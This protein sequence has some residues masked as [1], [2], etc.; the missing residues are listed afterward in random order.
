MRNLLVTTILLF[1]AVAGWRALQSEEGASRDAVAVVDHSAAAT[2]TPDGGVV[3]DA[4]AIE[5]ARGARPARSAPARRTVELDAV[6]LAVAFHPLAQRAERGDEQAMRMLSQRLGACRYAERNA[7]SHQARLAENLRVARVDGHDEETLVR[8][9]QLSGRCVGVT[10]EMLATL[11]KWTALLAESGDRNARLQY[12]NLARPDPRDPQFREKLPEVAANAR[13][14][15][16]Q[17]LA[18]GDPGALLAYQHYYSSN[19]LVPRDPFRAYAHGH[20]YV[21]LADPPTTHASRHGLA[22]AARQLS[23]QEI[24]LAE[25]QGAALIQRCCRR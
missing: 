4:T 7:G 20:A 21:Q 3:T 10:D 5:R 11:T 24:Q 19:Q 22:A 13:E 14:Y 18:E 23:P 2:T 16:D 6:P 8:A 17:L 15:L 1:A 9:A 25:R 12:Q